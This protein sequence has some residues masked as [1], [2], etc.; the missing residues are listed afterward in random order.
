MPNAVDVKFKIRCPLYLSLQY[1]LHSSND[2][3]KVPFSGATVKKLKLTSSEKRNRIKA[4]FKD[5]QRNIKCNKIFLYACHEL[6]PYFMATQFPFFKDH[7][8]L[9]RIFCTLPYFLFSE[10]MP[11]SLMSLQ[12]WTLQE[13]KASWS[14]LLKGVMLTR[15]QRWTNWQ[16]NTD[17]RQEKKRRH[18]RKYYSQIFKVSGHGIRLHI[19]NC[20]LNPAKWGRQVW[21]IIHSRIRA[22][23][24]VDRKHAINE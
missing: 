23:K 9:L 10:I 6:L 24:I 1:K 2:R 11:L 18:H 16:W 5:R 3:Q 19:V 13:N 22:T 14:G 8:F 15:W 4:H 21:L 12:S 17:S 7:V 20:R